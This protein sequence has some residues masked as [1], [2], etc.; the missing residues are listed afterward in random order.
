MIALSNI[1]N[2]CYRPV[3]LSK[4][5]GTDLPLLR[6]G[7]CPACLKQKANELGVR[8]FRELKGRKLYFI[9]LT[10]RDECAPI[11]QTSIVYNCDTGE[12]IK[13]STD[14]VRYPDF[15]DLAKFTWCRNYRKRA[16]RYE[17]LIEVINYNNGYEQQI[18]SYPT[19]YYED[20][21][22]LLKRYRKRFPDTLQTY[23][24]VPEYGSLGYR[25]HYH[26]MMADLSS[27]QIAFIEQDWSDKFG[28]VDIRVVDS[29]ED[30]GKIA[31]YVGKYTAKGKYDCP[32]IEQ[33]KCIKP[34][35]AISE[36][37]GLREPMQLIN[38]LFPYMDNPDYH[39]VNIGS[40]RKGKEVYVLIPFNLHKE[41]S[42]GY[43]R[44][45]L[46][47]RKYML[48]GF[49]YPIPKY[50]IQKMFY[51]K[52][53]KVNEDG[54]R[55]YLS[56]ATPLQKQVTQTLLRNL[57]QN[58]HI[59]QFGKPTRPTSQDV[60]AANGS[61]SGYVSPTISEDSLRKDFV[62]ELERDSIF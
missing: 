27:E 9:T 15:F 40:K 53:V 14:V 10:Y 30:V 26:L 12:I 50:I 1:S 39:I 34:R 5:T 55:T 48:N 56:R 38:Q 49:S 16:K 19:V 37:F 4:L 20:V 13:E 17:P 2:R 47:M 61:W 44:Q 3:S 35:R 31:M 33:G 6:C 25:P 8:A 42:D 59:Q 62:F 60:Q 54:R 46:N 58:L 18:C 43:V 7:K 36:N 45:M 29:N 21:K 52:I 57:V 22:K 23:L 28:N 24:C 41:Q 51:A 11:C 32:Y